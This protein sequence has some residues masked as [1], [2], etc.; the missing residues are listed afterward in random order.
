MSNP[1]TT[2]TLSLGEIISRIFAIVTANFG[3]FFLLIMITLLPETVIEL[4]GGTEQMATVMGL[5]PKIITE[6]IFVVWV[7]RHLTGQTVT[8]NSAT[9][10]TVSRM[11]TLISI[12]I[13][14]TIAFVVAIIVGMLPFLLSRLLMDLGSKNLLFIIPSLL[15]I[16]G[17]I[18]FLSICWSVTVPVAIVEQKSTIECFK[19]SVLLTKGH[20]AIIL[21]LYVLTLAIAGILAAI[22][23]FAMGVV[24]G[25]LGGFLNINLKEISEV[26]GL[27]I[28]IGL[29]SGVL[30]VGGAV[31]YYDLRSIK[32]GVHL[33]NLVDLFD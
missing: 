1:S 28:A 24:F 27:N 17:L 25:F 19:R 21:A 30:W 31:I 14:M 26:I 33:E 2:Q 9:M 6:G 20:R 5:F 15:L 29:I 11:G 4:G 10:P 7:Y 18:S 16:G 13:L 3:K 22:L 12:R 32:E 8:L 23:S